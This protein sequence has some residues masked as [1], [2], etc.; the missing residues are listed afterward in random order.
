MRRIDLENWIY[1]YN[2]LSDDPEAPYDYVPITTATS[3]EIRHI[4]G[5][6]NYVIDKDKQ[7]IR[8]YGFIEGSMFKR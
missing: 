1:Y 6:D 7:E 4:F 3:N 5:C 2:L 8:L